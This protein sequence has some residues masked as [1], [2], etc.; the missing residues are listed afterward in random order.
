MEKLDSWNVEIRHVWHR[1]IYNADLSSSVVS[2]IWSLVFLQWHFQFFRL[3][4][5][6]VPLV[7]FASLSLEYMIYKHSL[8]CGLL[9]N[10]TISKYVKVKC[11]NFT[12]YYYL[13][14]RRFCVIVALYE[15]KKGEQYWCTI[16]THCN[17][18]CWN[19][20]P[21]TSNTKFCRIFSLTFWYYNLR[22]SC[23]CGSS[24]SKI[25]KRYLY[26]RFPFL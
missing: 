6:N 7:S 14:L 18:D 1:S 17:T 9:R 15:Y 11:K 13:F 26:L 10:R 16:S 21:L 23:I 4:S 2:L 19:I 12:W 3:K 25:F 24:K 20:N 8:K 5:L 22:A